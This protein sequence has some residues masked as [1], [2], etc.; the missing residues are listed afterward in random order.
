MMCIKPICCAFQQKLN[1]LQEKNRVKTNL[2]K[3]YSLNC[4]FYLFK[5][6]NYHHCN[7]A[8]DKRRRRRQHCNVS[9][10]DMTRTIIILWRLTKNKIFTT[11]INIVVKSVVRTV[12]LLLRGCVATLSLSPKK[13]LIAEKKNNKISHVS[14]KCCWKKSLFARNHLSK[15]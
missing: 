12:Q 4:D 7:I 6:K 5:P 14:K 8:S 15:N 11:K 3:I 9:T 13:N 1:S 10:S 2:K